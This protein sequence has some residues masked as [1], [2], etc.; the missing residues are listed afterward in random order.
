[1]RT[2]LTYKTQKEFLSALKKALEG[3]LGKLTWDDMAARAGIEPRALKTYRLPEDS[4]NYRSMPGVAKQALESVLSQPVKTS[5]SA[6]VLVP[7]LAWL[8][9]SQ[10]RISVI[11]RQMIS[12]LDRRRGSRNGLTEEE[13]KVM[14]MVSRYCLS[15]GLKDFGGEIHDLLHFCTQPLETW[16][17]IPEILDAGYG[18]TILI[19][20]D[21]GIPTPEA[22]E[23]AVDFSTVTA[24]IEEELFSKLMEAINKYSEGAGNEYYTMIREFIVRNPVVSADKLFSAGKIVPSVLWMAVQQ[25]YYEP[26]PMAL[27]TQGTVTLCAHCNSLMKPAGQFMRCQSRACASTRPATAGATLPVEDCRRVLRGIRQYW[28]E[29]GIDEIRLLDLLKSYASPEILGARFRRGLGGLAFYE[30][31][32]VVIPDW[33]VD[34]TPSYLD[35]LVAAMGETASRV[36]CLSLSTA[37]GKIIGN[38]AHS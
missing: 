3:K 36:R 1:M 14:A 17:K 38:G 23:L 24:H 4:A 22:E 29:P 18:S 32:W 35:R 12:G 10:A 11:D 31:K 5:Q 20:P 37:A 7:A 15:H 16:P 21:Y 26:M 30:H 19:N 13:R 9:S 28:V 27:A 25:D 8:V 6:L 33:L 34:S 2:N